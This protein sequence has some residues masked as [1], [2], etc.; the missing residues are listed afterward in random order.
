MNKYDSSKIIA[1]LFKYGKNYKIT[2]NINKSNII[3][4]N[5]CSVRQKAQDKFFNYLNII[6]KIK[7]KNNNLIVIVLGCVASQEKK[8]L[9]LKFKFIDIIFGTHEINK[10]CFFINEFKKYKKKIISIKFNKNINKNIN[11]IKYLNTISSK[12]FVSIMEGCNKF[13]SYCVVPYARGKEISRLPNEIINEINNLVNNGINEVNLL[14]QNV[15]SYFS[16]FNNNKKCK[17]SDLLYLIFK[18]NGIKRIKFTTSHPS[19]FNDDLIFSYKKNYK[20]MDFLHLPV[21]SG[22]DRILK[23]MRRN[24]TIKKYKKII[25]NLLVIRPNMIFSSDFI[26]GFPTES[27]YDFNLTLNLINEIKF[28]NSYA[29][30]YSPR[31]GTKSYNMKDNVSYVE[32]KNRLF[33]LQKLLKKNLIY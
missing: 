14:G 6:K 10:I 2:N 19:D 25:K 15:S 12:S 32:K 20:I 13:C 8:N 1:Y 5:S 23:I 3:I 29:F 7:I 4:L 30:I 16:Y 9:F 17:F 24:Y 21:Q 31:P 11:S 26:V 22:S 28:D 27:D 33:E 18:I